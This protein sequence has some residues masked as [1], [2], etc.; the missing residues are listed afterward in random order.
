MKLTHLFLLG[1]WERVRFSGKKVEKY[2]TWEG[3]R[4]NILT[5]YI[6]AVLNVQM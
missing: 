2:P 6:C 5:K 1:A 4:V 3:L